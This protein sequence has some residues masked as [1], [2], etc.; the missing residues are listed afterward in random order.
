[1][2]LCAFDVYSTQTK[3]QLW[4]FIPVNFWQ[5]QNNYLAL[6]LFDLILA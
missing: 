5:A 6:F 2:R 3:N 1:M 4:N